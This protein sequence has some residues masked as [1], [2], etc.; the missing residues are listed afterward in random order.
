[1][2]TDPIA[3]MLTRI[4]NAVMAQHDSVHVPVS[5][6]KLFIAKILKEEGFIRD[7]DV[8]KSTT[9]KMINIRLQYNEKREPS[10]NGIK[11]ISKP[12]LRVYVEKDAIP[13]VYGNVGISILSTSQG[14]MTGREAKR[15]GIGGEVLCYVW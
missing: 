1:M 11:R 4:R 12:G 8:L 3:D 10:L 2:T 14:L 13:N 7:Y 15:K 6:I 5:K 9:Q